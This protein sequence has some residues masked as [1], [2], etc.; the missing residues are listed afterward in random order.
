[1]D[2]AIDISTVSL[3]RENE[4]IFDAFSLRLSER[5]I[6]LIGRNGSG[7]STLLRLAAGLIEPQS[8][9]VTVNGVDVA[10]DR[11]GALRTVGIL[12]QNPDHQI[13]FPT[14]TEEVAFGL[15]QQGHPRAEAKRLAQAALAEAGRADWADRLCYALS[16]GQRQMVCLI[17]VL[18]MRPD[19]VLFDEPFA[20]LDLPA[21]LRI[22]REIAALDQNVVTVTHDPRRI[23]GY[24]RVI[25]LEAGRIVADG[26]PAEVMPA[27]LAEMDRIARDE[28]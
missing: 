25:W 16:Q 21:T 9:R 23:D 27:Y 5:R 2:R 7:K 15:E 28:C 26:R 19:W 24:D 8:G 20:S 18:A 13:I 22:E 10:K 6:A 12:F 11:A 17:S 14:V 4:R 3:R 1:M